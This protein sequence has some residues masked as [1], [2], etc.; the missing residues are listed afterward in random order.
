[1]A[2]FLDLPDEIFEEILLDPSLTAQDISR[3]SSSFKRG[4][5]IVFNSG[6]L[7]KRLMTAHYPNITCQIK[8]NPNI[9]PHIFWYQTFT[10]RYALTSRVRQLMTDLSNRYFDKNALSNTHMEH[11]LQQNLDFE[12]LLIIDALRE[13]TCKGDPDTDL[14]LRYYGEQVIQFVCQHFLGEKWM[15]FKLKAPENQDYYHGLVMI[16]QWFQPL[17]D[18]NIFDIRGKVREIA[19][20]VLDKLKETYPNHPIFQFDKT[21]QILSDTNATL[22]EDRFGGGQRSLEILNCLNAVFFED[23]RF[24]GNTDQYYSPVNSYIDKVLENRQG[25]PIT[26]CILYSLIAKLLGVVILPINFPRHFLLR[27]KDQQTGEEFY[28]D[29]FQKGQRNTSEQIRVTRNHNP[30]GCASASPMEVFQRM[31]RNLMTCAQIL[32][33]ESMNPQLSP[34]SLIRKALELTKLIGGQFEYPGFL[35]CQIY[36]QL[37]INSREVM[38]ELDNYENWPQMPQM[39]AGP[40]NR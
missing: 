40:P 19:L 26:L 29:A 21:E 22:D 30:Q 10:A 17:E 23:F 8:E 20:A 34:N 1:M 24:H 28:I 38:Q 5:D 9:E 6:Q 31:V 25:I 27:W 7:W 39:L 13:L 33:H 16:S 3:F 36:L 37:S 18:V 4:R 12:G 2:T 35:L 11:F 14:T 32:E 15:E